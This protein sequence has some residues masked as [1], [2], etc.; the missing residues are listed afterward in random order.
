MTG[1][2][3]DVTER[4]RAEE[5]LTRSRDELEDRVRERTHELSRIAEELR[6]SEEA[7]RLLVE[8]NPVGV[9]RH[10]YDT[11]NK[12]SKRLHCNDAQL[13][14]LGYSSLNEYLEEF[15]ENTII[16]EDWNK[17][18]SSLISEGKIVNFPAQMKRKDGKIIWVLLNASTRSD[19]KH[20]FI[21]G[22]MTEIS[23]QKRTE[24][25]L[26]SAQ[27]M[28][29]AMAAE[30]VMADERTRQH[31]ATDLHDTVVQTLG[32]AKLRSQL[33]QESIPPAVKPIY[34]ELQDMISQSITQARFIMAEMSPPVLY[35]LGFVPALEWLTEQIE[36]RHGIPITFKGSNG[37]HALIH[38]IQVL[39]FQAT[40]ELLMNVVKHSRAENAI[41]K[42]SGDGNRVR[43]EVIDNG[44]GFD[45]RQAFRTDQSSGGYGLFSIRERLRHFGGEL[46][47]WSKPGE[48]TRVVMTAPRLIENDISE[49]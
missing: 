33:I 49:T 12:K 3:M 37:P 35:E 38:E 24:D 40:R 27:K 5:A 19:E 28:L 23:E 6:K 16:E 44:S 7:Y 39:L 4:K 1:I 41:V 15:P 26:R 10:V 13:K 45:K 2:N 47:I 17:Y 46:K 43:I 14:L 29:R 8:L 25:R 11:S 48:G 34:T 31:F 22:A 30:I 21:E 32:A 18:I 42:L 20:L 36:S 9:F